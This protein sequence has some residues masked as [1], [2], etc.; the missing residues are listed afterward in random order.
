MASFEYKVIEIQFKDN[1]F[2][3]N[4]GEGYKEGVSIEHMLNVMDKLGWEFIQVWHT[5]FYFKKQR[6]V[7][8]QSISDLLSKS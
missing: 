3:F 1:K 8:S 2:L 7:D 4:D 5:L 6:S